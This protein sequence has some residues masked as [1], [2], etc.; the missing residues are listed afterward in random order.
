MAEYA[1]KTVVFKTEAELNEAIR[2]Y[3]E[4]TVTHFVTSTVMKS[5]SKTGKK[6][7]LSLS[8]DVLFCVV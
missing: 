1:G 2:L 5:F 3:E 6:R 7:L 4:E 8:N